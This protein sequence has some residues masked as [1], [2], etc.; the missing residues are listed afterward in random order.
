MG[1]T[2]RKPPNYDRVRDAWDAWG[3]L[4]KPPGVEPVAWASMMFVLHRLCRYA[5]YD[6]IRPTQ[7]QLAD[8]MGLPR[9]MVKTRLDLAERLGL[10]KRC[11]SNK[12]GRWDFTTYE[13]LL[14]HDQS[15][16][17]DHDQSPITDRD[18]SLVTNTPPKKEEEKTGDFVSMEKPDSACG[19]IA[20]REEEVTVTPGEKNA[21]E[22]LVA[23]GERASK[24]VTRKSQKNPPGDLSRRMAHYFAEKWEAVVHE[25]PEFHDY[26]CMD[27]IQQATGYFRSVFFKPAA[28]RVYTE[29][30]VVTMIDEFM[31]AVQTSRILIKPNQSVLMRFTGKWG[32]G[33]KAAPSTTNTDYGLS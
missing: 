11:H 19:R 32:R 21:D 29:D 5:K 31:L 23:Y 22:I 13:L 27:G 18:Q 16:V 9:M 10:I 30:A 7:Q 26:R 25:R 12:G 1:R 15:V 28:G 6:V 24:R 33:R 20:S 4:R 3:Q 17:T 8:D 14:D 2:E